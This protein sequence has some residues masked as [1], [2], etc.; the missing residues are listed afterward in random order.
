MNQRNTECL[1]CF[2]VDWVASVYTDA[3]RCSSLGAGLYISPC[4]TSWGFCQPV[5]VPPDGVKT[6]WC[7]SHSSNFLS[8]ANL[9]R[10]CTLPLIQIMNRTGP[11]INPW[12]TPLATG[13]QLVFLLLISTLWTWLFK[14]LPV[15]LSAYSPSPYLIS[16]YLI[17]RESVSN[18]SK[19]HWIK[20]RSYLLLSLHLPGQFFHQ[21][22]SSR[23]S[24]IVS[25]W[26]SQADYSWRFSKACKRGSWLSS[27]ESQST[28]SRRFSWEDFLWVI[29]PFLLG[30]SNTRR[31]C[32][33]L[34]SQNETAI[35][36]CVFMLMCFK[37]SAQMFFWWNFSLCKQRRSQIR[38]TWRQAWLLPLHGVWYF[39][40]G[41]KSCCRR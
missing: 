12:G 34:W 23:W 25:L 17:L 26:W 10:G 22:N 35:V 3:W 40:L 13:L 2:L 38:A 32:L 19:P 6:E 9:K 36:I 15:H 33:Q 31:T 21:R 5:Q 29:V 8:S 27:L 28:E 11:R 16:F 18:A 41:G 24:S 4:W 20:G 7:I 30:L 1:R 37:N 39:F 14:K